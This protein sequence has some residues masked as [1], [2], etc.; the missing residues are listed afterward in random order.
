MGSQQLFTE[1]TLTAIIHL[2]ARRNSPTFLRVL[3]LWAVVLIAN[4]AGAHVFAWFRIR[5]RARHFRRMADRA[6]GLDAHGNRIGSC[7]DHYHT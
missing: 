6:G 1:N 2:L 3:R 7:G 5:D 4:L